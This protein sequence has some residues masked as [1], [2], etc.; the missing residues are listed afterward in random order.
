[1]I[2][3]AYFNKK[4][5]LISNIIPGNYNI[6]Y[7]ADSNCDSIWAGDWE[8]EFNE[9]VKLPFRSDNSGQLGFRIRVVY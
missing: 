4:P 1:M 2:T 7:I 6:K 3:E 8:K 9:T 5:Y